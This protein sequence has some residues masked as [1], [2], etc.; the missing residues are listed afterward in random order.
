MSNGPHYGNP[1]YGTN[2]PPPPP[3]S[4]PYPGKLDGNKHDGVSNIGDKGHDVPYKHWD[5]QPDGIVHDPQGGGGV[6][7]PS[8][9]S[10]AQEKHRATPDRRTPG[11][12]PGLGDN[13][14]APHGAIM[15]NGPNG[16]QPMV[17]MPPGPYPGGHVYGQP[18][19][20]VMGGHPPPPPPPPYMPPNNQPTMPFNAVYSVEAKKMRMGEVDPMGSDLNR[21][22]PPPQQQQQQQPPPPQA[23]MENSFQVPSVNTSGPRTHPHPFNGTHQPQPSNPLG[24]PQHIAQQSPMRMA[25]P[26]PP[27]QMNEHWEPQSASMQNSNMMPNT[28][29]LPSTPAASKS[30]PSDDKS[31]KKKRKRCGNCPGCLRK[32]NCGECGPCK[33]VRSHQ[34][35]KMRKC[36][37]LKTK[38]EKVRES[39]ESSN[40]SNSRP[41]S[42]PSASTTPGPSV[43]SPVSVNSAPGYPSPSP[44][45]ECMSPRPLKRAKSSQF[46]N[47]YPKS[48]YGQMYDSNGH[49]YP[50]NYPQQGLPP[51][52]SSASN[53]P[54]PPMHNQMSNGSGNYNGN[55]SPMPDNR[56]P[57]MPPGPMNTTQQ[58]E[59]PIENSNRHKLMNNRLKT[60]I[61]SRQNQKEMGQNGASNGGNGGGGNNGPMLPQYSSM[62]PSSTPTPSVHPQSYS[63]HPYPQSLPQMHPPTTTSSSNAPTSPHPN[64]VQNNGNFSSQPNSNEASW[65]TTNNSQTLNTSN[66]PEKSPTTLQPTSGRKTPVFS[67]PTSTSTESNGPSNESTHNGPLYSSYYGNNQATESK[68]QMPNGTIVNG[69]MAAYSNPNGPN[70]NNNN[71]NNNGNTVNGTAN[72]SHNSQ[73]VSS[74]PNSSSN[75]SNSSEEYSNLHPPPPSTTSTSSQSH[76]PS[77][78]PP[79]PPNQGQQSQSSTTEN[80]SNS[81]NTN[82]YAHSGSKVSQTS[83]LSNLLKSNR[84]YQMNGTSASAAPISTS[85]GSISSPHSTSSNETSALTTNGH[86]TTANNNNNNNDHF[87]V[88]T[89]TTMHHLS[90]LTTSMNTSTDITNT[91]N[92]QPNSQSYYASPSTNSGSFYSNS[93]LSVMDKKGDL[94]SHLSPAT[95]SGQVVHGIEMVNTAP[96][97][98]HPSTSIVCG[99]NNSLMIDSSAELLYLDS[100]SSSLYTP[101]DTGL[102]TT[103]KLLSTSSALRSP[104]AM[105]SPHRLT[106]LGSMGSMNSPLIPQSPNT[107]TTSGSNNV[108]PPVSTFMFPSSIRSDDWW[109]KNDSMTSSS[110]VTA[111]LVSASTSALCDGDVDFYGLLNG[112]EYSLSHAST[113]AAL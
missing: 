22:G 46:P 18:P 103:A 92:Y 44:G 67:V 70:S 90:S 15:V 56:R 96:S 41:P 95:S 75:S 40:G 79:P 24:P 14:H 11:R 60:L 113:T 102:S 87:L 31:T 65:S 85:N 111:K 57:Q 27:Q 99:R 50:Q 66:V 54:H 63:S 69:N 16:M 86:T 4:V 7:M 93:T 59:P 35:C 80:V 37:Q 62:S 12:S 51:P 74:N 1:P 23:S 112:T 106:P 53:G 10:S 98:I 9:P 42:G 100:S 68:T 81:A 91:Y 39:K 77:L 49:G 5:T 107:S 6:A 43:P 88:N 84:P 76:A 36:D 94:D 108:L 89:T 29:S 104:I 33:S 47:E 26:G 83:E 82:G 105:H 48:P 2:Y 20:Y 30:P 73:T 17:S 58:D 110:L 32:D 21:S 78:P 97:A 38:K 28:P 3:M 109:D 71:N 8:R 19:M 45:A 13:N 52:P 64:S 34:I 72:F 101:T 55:N 61:Q 25:P